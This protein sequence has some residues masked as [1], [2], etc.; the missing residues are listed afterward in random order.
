MEPTSESVLAAEGRDLD[1]LVAQLVFGITPREVRVAGRCGEGST[2]TMWTD[3]PYFADGCCQWEELIKHQGPKNY[4]E[5]WE[6][7]GSVVAWMRQQRWGLVIT[8][9]DMVSVL[10]WKDK[11][12]GKDYIRLHGGVSQC[13]SIPVAVCRA[14]CLAILDETVTLETGTRFRFLPED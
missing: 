14:A 11:G 12:R 8:T 5:S 6:T 3:N 10:F 4:S 7:V 13:E 9:L 2:V 1:K